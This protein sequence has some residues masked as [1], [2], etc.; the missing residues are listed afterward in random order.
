MK[1]EI[2]D[3][4]RISGY[5]RKT[6]LEWPTKDKQSLEDYLKDHED[7][8]AGEGQHFEKFKLVPIYETGIICGKRSLKTSM[9]LSWEEEEGVDVGIGV[10]PG[11]IGIR[12][13]DAT[14]VEVYLVAT[15]MNCLRRVPVDRLKY[16]GG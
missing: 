8:F 3:K 4:V 7:D 15:R 16:V 12:Q 10:T 1:L 13:W 5:M 14:H 2:G 9:T 11:F 6:P